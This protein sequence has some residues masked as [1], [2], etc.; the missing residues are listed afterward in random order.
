MTGGR[1]YSLDVRRNGPRNPRRAVVGALALVL[2]A[3]L[4]VTSAGPTSAT[5]PA[6]SAKAA[7]TPISFRI[8]SFNILGSWHTRAGHAVSYEAPGPMRAHLAAEA[9][10]IY[11]PGVVGFQEA[12]PDQVPVMAAELP[13]Y[14]FWPGLDFG[15]EGVRNNIAWDNRRF[16]LVAHNKIVI[17]F[18]GQTRY[19]PYI[20]LQD[21]A[22]GRQFWVMNA[23]NTPKRGSDSWGFEERKAQLDAEIAK[24][25][26]LEATGLPVFFVGD[27]NDRIYTYCQV[28]SRTTLRAPQGYYPPPNDCD[29]PPNTHIDWIFGSAGKVGWSDY[30]YDRGALV[31]QVTDHHVTW[32]TA[33]L[34]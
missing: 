22:T 9:I 12:E 8:G 23:H 6:E 3:G 14:D 19:L 2:L 10:R 33:T 30:K 17:T 21:K 5:G 31:A 15:W 27:L 13:Q 18:L 26:E 1:R 7:V 29:L 11:A 28:V 24:L 25:R 32:A 34:H 16:T 4:G 20:R